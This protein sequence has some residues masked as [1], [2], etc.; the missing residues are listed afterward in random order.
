MQMLSFNSCKPKKGIKNLQVWQRPL[1]SLQQYIL[2]LN[3]FFDVIKRRLNHRQAERVISASLNHEIKIYVTPEFSKELYR[4]HKGDSDPILKF[5]KQLPTLPIIGKDEIEKLIVELKAI[6]FPDRQNAD[7]PNSRNRSDLTHLAYCLHHRLTGFIT[8]EK[9][10][11]SASEELR[12]AYF[13][14]ILSL[15]DLAIP[16]CEV[17]DE[18]ILSVNVNREK[19]TIRPLKECQRENIEKFLMT[20]Q[21]KTENLS[22]I[23]HPG[24]DTLPRRRLVAFIGNQIVG[25]ASWDNPQSLSRDKN[26]YLFVNE[27]ASGSEMIMDHVLEASIKD[28][29]PF[30]SM[31][32]TLNTGFGQPG[33]ISTAI[34]R[35]FMDSSPKNSLQSRKRLSKFVFNGVV[36]DVNWFSFQEKFME[37]TNYK[38]PSRIP[39]IAEFSNTGIIIKNRNGS[40]VNNF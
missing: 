34:N 32:V 3:V 26:L 19:L 35:G 18:K 21:V 9:A 12:Q 5:A 22:E 2:D 28:A 15:S 27:S 16:S 14:E 31:V 39:T 17:S 20:C 37:L 40:I 29:K 11:L 25:V 13:I 8:S 7:K 24:T 23:L 10:I 38:L 1:L 30:Y 6:V 36:S 4:H 33:V